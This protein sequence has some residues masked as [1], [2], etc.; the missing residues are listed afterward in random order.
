MVLSNHPYL[1]GNFAPVR[2]TFSL[3]ICPYEGEI[4]ADLAGGQYVRNGSNPLLDHKVDQE[5]HWFD[6]DGMLSGV[7]FRRVGQTVQPEFVNQYLVTDLFAYVSASQLKRPFLPSIATLINPCTS[8]LRVL[9]L[10][11]RTVMLHIVSHFA[12]SLFPIGK[13]SVA[14]TAVVYHDGRALATCE[15]GPPL[16]FS[17]PSLETVGWF[18]GANTEGEPY[19]QYG[20][21]FGGKSRF[22]LMK[23]WTTAHPRVDPVT[24]EFVAFHAAFIK[25][26]VQYSVIPPRKSE[27]SLLISISIPG[28]S[29]PKMMHD[30]G[31]SRNHTVILDMPLSFNPMNMVK[32]LPVLFFDSKERSRFGIFPRYQ[33][34]AI[35][36]FDTNPCCIFHTVN[37]W[38]NESAISLLVCRLTTAALVFSAANLPAPEVTPI[39]PEYAEEDKPQIAQQWAL[40]AIEI[41]FSSVSLTK[42][43]SEARYVYGCSTSSAS[44]SVSLGKAAK[45]DILAKMDAATLIARG[46][47]NP[48]QPIK[49][50]VDTRSIEEI[51]ASSDPNDH[52]RLFSMPDGWFAQEPRFVP[53]AS[54]TDEDDGW[55]LTYVFDE[56]QLGADGL[57]RDDAIGEL[58]V[59]DAKRMQEV[60]ARIKLP[61]R[62]PY[63]FHGA[64]FSEEEIERQRPYRV[65]KLG[66]QRRDIS[67]LR[68]ALGSGIREMIER[69]IG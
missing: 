41:E 29:S 7:L 65:R 23:Q 8:A 31:V 44:Y 35:R 62:V 58:W 18:D 38:E 63:G 50:C 39:P 3:T 22:A 14:N 6:G 57:C 59:I 68:D 4:P 67:G 53:R 13:T 15:S 33:P 55:L 21:A 52:I 60:V 1:S 24:G 40:S 54:G 16:R 46:I 26:Y 27:Q 30:F 9:L 34:Q 32:G 51:L 12:G 69:W 11:L 49:G 17:L 36:W 20:D 66:A 10:V 2:K 5:A 64:W 37:C 48:P 47:E 45:I 19:G 61:Q 25:P 28:L 42:A 43:M 56:S